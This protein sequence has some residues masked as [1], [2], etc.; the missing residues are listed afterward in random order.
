MVGCEK[1]EWCCRGVIVAFEEGPWKLPRH[2]SGGDRTT[3]PDTVMS[4]MTEPPEITKVRTLASIH[5]PGCERKTIYHQEIGN[6]ISHLLGFNRLPTRLLDS[7]S[8]TFFL[9]LLYRFRLL[10]HFEANPTVLL[11]LS[12]SLRPTIDTIPMIRNT[13]PRAGSW[14]IH[15]RSSRGT[16]DV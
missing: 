14:C 6:S 4:L 9:P 2:S 13:I 16:A 3:Y 12:T 7:F 15:M 5:H 1:R 11:Y 10:R 8:C